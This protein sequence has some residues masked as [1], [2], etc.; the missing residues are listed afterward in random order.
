M[1][2]HVS[3]L[4]FHVCQ[5]GILFLCV[6]CPE[7]MSV[8]SVSNPSCRACINTNM[9]WSMQSVPHV[10]NSLFCVCHE[11]SYP[12]HLPFV[13]C[14][15]CQTPPALPAFMHMR[16]GQCDCSAQQ[17]CFHFS[18][19]TSSFFCLLCPHRACLCR[20]CQCH[21]CKPTQNRSCST[22]MTL[23]LLHEL[24]VICK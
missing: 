23:L 8:C 18:N 11:D 17:L 3:H 24:V 19:E 21:H 2:A 13:N 9:V 14:H 16:P 5:E 1:S 12:F 22:G 4:L 6:V 20:L 15:L 10:S 7:S